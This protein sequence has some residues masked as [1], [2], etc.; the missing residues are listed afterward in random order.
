MFA[1][2]EKHALVLGGSVAGLL[3]ARVLADFF[4]RVVVAERDALPSTISNRR[5]GVPQDRHVHLLWSRGGSSILEDLFPGFTDELIRAG[6]PPRFDGDLSKV[7]LNNG[8]HP[9]PASGCFDDFQFVLPSRPLLE[10]C[11]R[12]RVRRINNIE[13]R[14]AH[15]IVEL[16]T[17]RDHISGAVLRRRDR[18]AVVDGADEIVEADLVVD[19]MGRAGRTPP[20]LLDSL[21]YG[22]PV[23]DSLDVRLMYSSFFPV[24]IP[25]GGALRELAVVIGPVPGRPTGMALFAN[26]DN[27]WMFTVSGLAGGVE[28]PQRTERNAGFIEKKFAPMHVVAALRRSEV[29]GEGAQHRMPATRWRRYDKMKRWP[30]GLLAIGDAICSS[31]PSTPKE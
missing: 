15:D 29:I 7:Y 18:E 12:Q 14:D 20:A 4:D 5:G 21:G 8:G 28:P 19:A 27:T 31:I 6:A 16:V 23:E 26:E 11:V 17:D 25:P 9:L 30:T 2:G 24:R 13:L 22:R 3:A 10:G 1:M